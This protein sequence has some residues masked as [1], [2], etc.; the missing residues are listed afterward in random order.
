[1]YSM[2]HTL[3]KFLL[4]GYSLEAAIARVTSKPASWLKRPEL[5]R[6]Q[7]GDIANLT[8]F[9]VQEEQVALT[10]SEGETRLGMQHIRP[11]GVV[12]NGKYIAI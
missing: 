1:V 7:T 4:L 8:I 10:D 6:I 5:G 9:T 11:E 2:A 12:V 3:D